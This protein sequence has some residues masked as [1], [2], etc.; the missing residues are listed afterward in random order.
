MPPS[1]L[2]D[3]KSELKETSRAVLPVEE[4]SA[5]FVE[6]SEVLFGYSAVVWVALVVDVGAVC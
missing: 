1:S 3:T 6:C 2:L 5:E 4:G